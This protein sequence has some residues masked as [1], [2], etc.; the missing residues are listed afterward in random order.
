MSKQDS[1][2]G[3]ATFKGNVLEGKACIKKTLEWTTDV[4]FGLNGHKY[5][6]KLAKEY[7]R[8]RGLGARAYDIS[9][10]GGRT[11]EELW[12]YGGNDIPVF[13]KECGTRLGNL[14]AQEWKTY[15]SMYKAKPG[16]TVVKDGRTYFQLTFSNEQCPKCKKTVEGE[17]YNL[18]DKTAKP[19]YEARSLMAMKRELYG[20]GR[21]EGI[22][23]FDPSYRHASMYDNGKFKNVKGKSRSHLGVS[24]SKA[25]LLR[26]ALTAKKDAKKALKDA[27]EDRHI[28]HF[29]LDGLGDIYEILSKGSDYSHNVTGRELRYVWRNWPK[30]FNDDCVTFYNGF[31]GN[32]G[33]GDAVIV[34]CPW[35]EAL[36]SGTAGYKKKIKK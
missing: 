19:L 2:M 21:I 35:K 9:K 1:L 10:R 16:A 26:A 20:G 27:A 24:F 14:T 8:L 23:A 30:I 3:L 5:D 4:H 18:Y 36:Y 22:S 13:C 15:T 28:I 29:H 33:E 11:A 25:A 32:N 6:S 7:R 12:R 17:V 34:K 31:W